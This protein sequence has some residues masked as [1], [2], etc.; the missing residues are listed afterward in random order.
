MTLSEIENRIQAI[1]KEL[2]ELREKANKVELE[3]ERE[4]ERY[5]EQWSVN[6]CCECAHHL[7]IHYSPKEEEL[8]TLKSKIYKLET[9]WNDLARERLQIKRKEEEDYKFLKVFVDEKYILEYIKKIDLEYVTIDF[10]DK[11]SVR[12]KHPDGQRVAFVTGK[13][14]SP[15]LSVGQVIYKEK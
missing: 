9:E 14:I 11:Y 10:I 13:G 6:R 8:Y 7:E 12:M 5:A 3:V 15:E 4:K 1:I 2:D